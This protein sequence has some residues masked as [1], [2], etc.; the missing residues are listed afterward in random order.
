[1]LWEEACSTPPLTFIPYTT[2]LNIEAPSPIKLTLNLESDC[3]RGIA[4]LK[5]KYYNPQGC[6]LLITLSDP[7]VCFDQ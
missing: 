1:M 7:A 3:L 2:Q 4:S 5:H 6:S